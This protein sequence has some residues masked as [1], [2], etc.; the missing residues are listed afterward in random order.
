[1]FLE[2]RPDHKHEGETEAEHRGRNY[3]LNYKS[4]YGEAKYYN[5]LKEDP[6][7]DEV[8]SHASTHAAHHD[9]FDYL[10][11]DKNSIDYNVI[12][13]LKMIICFE[14]VLIRLIE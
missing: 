6:D 13:Y 1:M 12:V 14:L 10:D 2:E 8:E 3:C 4:R 7:N 9:E 5:C 11:S